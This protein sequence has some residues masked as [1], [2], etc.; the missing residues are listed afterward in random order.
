MLLP[1]SLDEGSFGSINGIVLRNS[2]AIANHLRSNDQYLKSLCK[3]ASNV[4]EDLTC[5]CLSIDRLQ[6][7]D[8]KKQKQYLLLLDEVIQL[9]KGVGNLSK[10]SMFESLVANGFFSIFENGTL[11]SKV[12]KSRQAAIVS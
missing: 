7:S 5:G 2:L 4:R 10:P 3:G 11:F 8:I 6:C 12:R 9:A 1:R